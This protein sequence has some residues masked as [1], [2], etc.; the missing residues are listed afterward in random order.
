MLNDACSNVC[1]RLALVSGD[2]DFA[3][4]LKTVKSLVPEKKLIV[5]IPSPNTRHIRAAAPEIR[6][7]ADNHKAL[8]PNKLI[9][10]CQFP[11]VI[12]VANSDPITKPSSW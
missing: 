5:Y 9:E 1:N 10:L 2:S 8:F 7:F 3:P 4:V 12:N 11:E 6:A